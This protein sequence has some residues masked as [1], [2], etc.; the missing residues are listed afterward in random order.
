MKKNDHKTNSIPSENSSE[1]GFSLIKFKRKKMKSNIRLG[2]KLFM[3]FILAG[4]SGALFAKV[5]MKLELNKAI[6]EIKQSSVN[7][8]SVI[9]NYN[10]IIKVVSPSLVTISDSEEKLMNNS[11]YDENM[12][13]IVISNDGT[14]F[15][16]YSKVKYLNE[17]YVKLPAKGSLP[18][19]AEFISGDEQID[20]AI[21]KIDY[22]GELNPIKIA[23]KE[24][25]RA[26]DGIAILSNSIGDEYIG[27]IIPGIITSTRKNYTLTINNK[28][29]SVLETNAVINN[30]NTGGA[31]CNY[32]GELIGIS[33]EII[34]N[35]IGS[36]GL[37]YAIDLGELEKIIN[38]STEAKGLLG[39]ID[40]SIVSSDS[41]KSDGFYISKVKKGGNAYK[42]GIKPT[43]ILIE[44]DGVS[45]KNSTDM[46]KGLKNKKSGDTIECK[47]MRNGEPLNISIALDEA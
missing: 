23:N 9:L 28:E 18:L 39:I 21:L 38:N 8:S 26:G 22:D 24:S 5:T 2:S 16:N 27:T 32:K 44:I 42:A 13:G 33:S 14:I 41:D 12:T 7:N 3:F 29:Y 25:V 43:D 20:I 46:A 15:T 4:I 31:L 6:E 40:G 47:V 17:I 35:K 36:E 30:R 11:Y 1:E 45:I 37:Y 19:K 34:T 10:D